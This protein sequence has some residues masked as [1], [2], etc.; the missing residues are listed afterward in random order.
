MAKYCSKCGR[1]LPDGVEKC[2]VCH[3]EE[4]EKLEAALFTQMT[5]ETEIWKEAQTEKKRPKVRRKPGRRERLTLYGAA[6][7]LVALTAFIIIFTQPASKVERAIKAGDYDRAFSIYSEKL[8]GQG[9]ASSDASIGRLL[10]KKA[11]ELCDG[12]E[13]GEVE[14]ESAERVFASLYSFGLNTE[15]IDAQYA[16][17][18]ELKGTKSLISRAERLIISEKY[19]EACDIFLSVPEDDGEYE[20]AQ[21]RA[22]ECLDMYA[23]AVTVE[24]DGHMSAG[25]YAAAIKALKEGNDQLKEYDTFSANIDAKLEECFE[26]YEEHALSEAENL[27]ELEEYDNA[28]NLIRSCIDSIGTETQALSQ[29]LEKY[30]GLAQGKTSEDAVKKADEL[31]DAGQYA[32]AFL[33]LES[34]MDRVEDTGEIERAVASLERRF[35]SDMCAKAE[36]TLGGDRENLDAALAVIEEAMAIR[37]LDGLSEYSDDLENLR[38]LDLVEGEYQSREGDIYRSSSEFEGVDGVKYTDGW[39]WGGDEACI[40]YVLDG[41]Y[42]LLEGT[43]AVRRSDGTSVSGYFE[44]WCDGECKY[45]SDTLSHDSQAQSFAWDISGCKELKLVF[46][47]NYE[48]ST[49]ENGFCYHGVCSPTVT[50]NMEE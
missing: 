24:A 14:E 34:T 5:A 48:T 30:A 33:E 16:H 2:P 8:M 26:R 19:L 12:F 41:G 49:A 11:S 36:E 50:K 47:C 10:E 43:L 1:T 28:V 23:K 3:S 18:E 39:I 29:A 35:V 17:F 20:G 40:V 32:D 22:A 44:V 13:R 46:H 4:S 38:P 45:T 27:A 42:D 15:G 6:V 7:L 9:K 21:A 37:P 31:Y 25:D